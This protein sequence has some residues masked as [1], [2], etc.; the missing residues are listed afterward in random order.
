M[1]VYQGSGVLRHRRR[2]HPAWLTGVFNGDRGRRRAAAPHTVARGRRPGHG[3]GTRVL[4]VGSLAMPVV[5]FGG[6]YGQLD[7]SASEIMDVLPA[8]AHASAAVHVAA[9][10]VAWLR[11]WCCKWCPN[12]TATP[13]C[14]PCSRSTS[15]RRGLQKRTYRALKQQACNIGLCTAQGV[16]VPG[17]GAAPGART[18][19]QPVRRAVVRRLRG[20]VGARCRSDGRCACDAPGLRMVY[21]VGGPT[22]IGKCSQTRSPA[23]PTVHLPEQLAFLYA[24]ETGQTDPLCGPGEALVRVGGALPC[25]LRYVGDAVLGIAYAAYELVRVG[26]VQGEIFTEIAAGRPTPWSSSTS[27]WPCPGRCRR[28]ARVR[29]AG[30]TPRPTSRTP[31]ASASARCRP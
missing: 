12:P 5:N 10:N 20:Q 8:M 17:R 30:T 31:P 6:D 21:E 2:R 27:G 18:R 7:L 15:R 14:A 24:D 4:G 23:N 22:G 29:S 13:S 28:T 25:V 19:A 1:S 16:R 9:A 26:F 3:G 11:R